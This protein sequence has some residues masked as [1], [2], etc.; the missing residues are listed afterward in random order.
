MKLA[1][2]TVNGMGEIPLPKKSFFE[3][4]CNRREWFPKLFKA[5]MAMAVVLYGCKKKCEIGCDDPGGNG[6]GGEEQKIDHRNPSTVKQIV[7]DILY[8]DLVAQELETFE[9][10][11][12]F[13]HEKIK[14]DSDQYDSGKSIHASGY[15]VKRD[16]VVAGVHLKNLVIG[17]SN[18][19]KRTGSWEIGDRDPS[20]C[21]FTYNLKC[22]DTK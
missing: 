6:G 13:L 2:S 20:A 9:E 10:A 5:G 4:K 8:K 1:T 22:P 7:E 11:L 14:E 3:E 12:D 21:E 17:S 18:C 19:F 16:N 15:F